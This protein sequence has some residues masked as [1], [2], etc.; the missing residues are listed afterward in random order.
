VTEPQQLA[1]ARRP[2]PPGWFLNSYFQIGLGAVLVTA[3]ELMLKKGASASAQTGAVAGWLGIAALASWWT[4]GGI[5]SYVLSFLSWL[6]VLRYIPLS[7]AFPLINAVHVLVPL[8][9]LLF[10]HEP[11]S[12]KRWGGIA[13]ILAGILVIMRPATAA[14]AEL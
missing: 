10:L 7:I 8:G 11:V 13:L 1:A 6:H 12:P 4:W 14:E 2:A 9:A 5:V 3:S